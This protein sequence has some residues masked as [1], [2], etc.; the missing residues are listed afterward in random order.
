MLI[1]QD[2]KSGYTALHFAKALNKDN[3]IE[4]LVEKVDSSIESYAG[5]LAYEVNDDYDYDY[6]EDEEDDVCIF[7]CVYP[8]IS[9]FVINF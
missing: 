4:Y 5:R 9:I 7:L 6:D 2:Y 1:L 3:L 8:S